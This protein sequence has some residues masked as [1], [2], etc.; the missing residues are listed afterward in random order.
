MSILYSSFDRLFR[1]KP[2]GT[3]G[4]K[5]FVFC[6]NRP[7]QTCTVKET[8]RRLKSQY[9]W[10]LG[11]KPIGFIKWRSKRW[12]FEKIC[13]QRG[14]ALLYNWRICIETDEPDHV[15][16]YG[17]LGLTE[18]NVCKRITGLFHIIGFRLKQS[19]KSLDLC[20]L[21]SVIWFFFI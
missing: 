8:L 7:V 21:S 17:A 19:V 1:N 5:T 11:T 2:L 13:H 9:N 12:D 18:I 16:S 15:F 20:R 4:T 10:P 14:F 3:S 6:S